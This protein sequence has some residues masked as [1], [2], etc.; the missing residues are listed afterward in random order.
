MP[1][2]KTRLIY[3]ILSIF[4][5]GNIHM[6]AAETEQKKDLLP[7]E[8][9]NSKRTYRSLI[10]K[11][12]L[13]VI[14]VSDPKVNQSAAAM[15]VNVG[16]YEDARE[17]QGQFHFLEHMLF[18]GTKKYPVVGEY[19]AYLKSHNGYSNAFT[20]EDHTNYHFE[21]SH[22]GLEGA[23]DRFAQFFI[24][25]L[26]NESETSK[27]VN[28]V[29]SEHQKNIPNDTWRGYQVFRSNLKKGHP[30]NHFSTGDINTL[31]NCTREVLIE[32]YEKFYSSNEMALCVLSNQSLDQLEKLVINYFS[33]IPNRNIKAPTYDENYMDKKETFKFL[34]I[35]PKSDIKKLEMS[36]ALPQMKEYRDHKSLEVLA[37][38]IGHEGKGTITSYLKNKGYITA[39]GS[40]GELGNSFGE[41]NIS[42][43]LTPAGRANYK[44]II[45]V[46]F[47]Y[48]NLLK[49][50]PFPEYYYNELKQMSL[51]DYQNKEEQEGTRYTVQVS[52]GLRL[53]TLD[54]VLTVPYL[55]GDITTETQEGYF[56][57]LSEL[58]P[59]NF[60]AS[61]TSQDVF[62]DQEEQ[63]YKAKFS[64][65]EDDSFY[66]QLKNQSTIKE[67]HLPDPNLFIPRSVEI[68]AE[69]PILL[70]TN[71]FAEVW[72]S[73][74]Q[75]FKLPKASIKFQ[76]LTNSPKESVRNEVLSA[77]YLACLTE[78]LNEETYPMVIAGLEYSA[79]QNYKG[80][81]LD[82]NGYS[83][84]IWDFVKFV[85]SK[86]K[87]V[88]ITE[89]TFNNLKDKMTRNYKNL[90]FDQAYKQALT[91]YH[92]YNQQIFYN[93]TEKLKELETISLKE[94][95][96]YSQKS[97]YKNIFVQGSI[98]GN[99]LPN[100]AQVAVNDFIKSLNAKPLEPKKFPER[101]VAQLKTNEKIKLSK[102][103]Q[104]NNSAILQAFTYGI[105]DPTRRGAALVLSSILEAPYYAKMRT[106]EHLGYIVW[107]SFDQQE[108][109]M[110][111][112]FIIQSGD[113]S[114]DYL[115][116]RSNSFIQSFRA[117]LENIDEKNLET[118]KKSIIDRKLE[119]PK[120][121]GEANARNFYR[122][123]DKERDFDHVATDIIAVKNLKKKDII[124]LYDEVVNM[125]KRKCVT[126]LVY[127]SEHEQ[128]IPT[129]T[130]EEIQKIK[131]ST[132]YKR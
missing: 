128:N 33:D 67:L 132:E 62:A 120:T 65:T 13:K 51:I 74:D 94:V 63:Y 25:P 86:L 110:Y 108:K 28:N 124:D 3:A 15:D 79:K 97:L 76:I 92:E 1:K 127:G 38:I 8:V 64:Y 89:E 90:V 11:N 19:S 80:I 130:T 30:A 44:E 115:S 50:S 73:Q 26:F 45:M 56:K 42:M 105:E 24:S 111:Q 22:E 96:A 32:G 10:L 109:N 55:F 107:S 131:K 18:L 113:Y 112:S 40:G 77:L 27:E 70:V 12:K 48:I 88:D 83:D 35:I 117:E 68:F 81:V 41:F 36:F 14:L 102:K 69:R 122:A 37:S 49:K 54:N 75:T 95:L 87:K 101:K 118:H 61:L 34:Q 116:E 93:E 20:A 103:L 114:A 29:N 21:V 91:L 66:Q 85:S 71:E 72:Y 39:L 16:S 5:L 100:D 106:E 52:A 9:N 46:V 57:I 7:P 4:L 104:I 59:A 43:S 99:L 6:T 121:M 23:L 125:N 60:M 126:V 31:K 58:A 53:H 47:A 84:R 129:T 78:C 98:Y 119:K 17:H 82:F 123:F 2:L